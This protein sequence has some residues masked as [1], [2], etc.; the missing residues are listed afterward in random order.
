MPGRKSKIG[1]NLPI[2]AIVVGRVRP[3]ANN[4]NNN[5]RSLTIES[6]SLSL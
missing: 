6:Q 4:N 3:P 5:S 2:L 1:F